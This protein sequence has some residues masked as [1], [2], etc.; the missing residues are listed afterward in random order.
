MPDETIEIEDEQIA[1]DADFIR[2][3]S[4]VSI[5]SAESTA[6][7]PRAVVLFELI[8]GPATS[9]DISENTALS[10]KRATQAS[11]E[12]LKRELIEVLVPESDSEGPVFGVLPRGEKAAIPIEQP[13]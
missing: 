2:G 8:E 7:S 9:Q 1:A 4:G 10:T 12:L 3:S 6:H 13:P 11:N 5:A